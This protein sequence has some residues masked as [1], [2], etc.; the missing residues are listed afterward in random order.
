M[1]DRAIKILMEKGV[2]DRTVR[3]AWAISDICRGG[4]FISDEVVMVG[5]VGD[6]LKGSLPIC[7]IRK[8]MVP[9]PH[10]VYVPGGFAPALEIPSLFDE[11][12]QLSGDNL[13]AMEE[14]D[15]VLAS[16]F[17]TDRMVSMFTFAPYHTFSVFGVQKNA[18]DFVSSD[19]QKR[20]SIL[21]RMKG[22]TRGEP[23]IGVYV[24]VQKTKPSIEEWRRLSAKVEG[25]R[26][27][28]EEVPR[29][30]QI[31]AT[32]SQM[33]KS[34]SKSAS[35]AVVSAV[36]G[37][38]VFVSIDEQNRRR[39]I[40]EG[41]GKDVPKCEFFLDDKKRCSK[42]GCFSRYKSK[43]IGERCPVGKW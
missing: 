32:I 39:A 34:A 10:V 16:F 8:N 40:C 15:G 42:C 38:P 3:M 28:P 12:V 19:D 31:E 13:Q 14:N 30:K 9:L 26:S 6:V 36:T 7:A 22:R 27:I 43:L 11:F 5:P 33:I 1:T 17:M 20:A 4:V 18:V 35:R 23:V 21:D 41:N 29:P 37:K 25:K 2:S 24:G